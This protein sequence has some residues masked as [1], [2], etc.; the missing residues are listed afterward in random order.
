MGTFRAG[1]AVFVA[2]VLG[3]GS[4]AEASVQ[5]DPIARLSLESGY[6]SNVLYNG[7]GGQG[8]G[9]VSPDL[10]FDARNHTW[11]LKAVVGGD[12]ISYP[13][14][15]KT[16]VWNQRGQVLFHSRPS[17]RWTVD[18]QTGLIYAFDPIG[19][20]QLGIFAPP[21]SSALLVGGKFRAAY[22]LDEDWKLAGLLDERL[23]EFEG[24]VGNASHSP[25]VELTRRL[26]H[27]LE[28]GGQYKFDFFQ[29]IGPGALDAHAHEIQAVARYRL[30]RRLLL[31]GTA[32]AAL[33]TGP[34]GSSA[35]VPQGGIQ[36]V[37]MW[38]GGGARFTLRHGVGLGLTATPGL[39]DALESGITTRLGR[40]FQ[41]H[42]DGGIW[43]SGT[44]PWGANSILG[45]GVAGSFDFRAADDL[46]VGVD[47]SRYARLDVYAPQ[48]NRNIVGLHV[49]WELRHSRGGP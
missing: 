16:T 6:D 29:G 27:R 13:Q 35:I 17:E 23:V 37:S 9:R 46:L 12:L 14:L 2:A 26:G 43:K 42:A 3:A 41:L 32:G 18:A 4:W 48:Y 15:A 10:G 39:F 44:I 7:Q 36:L 1:R 31:E 45:Y 49:T 28:A 25:G 5:V 19:L 11:D 40:K 21:G 20:A 30:E 34:D 38:R 22:R 8:M 33:W 47:A 24:G